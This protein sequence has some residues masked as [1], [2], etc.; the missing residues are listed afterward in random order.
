MS[1]QTDKYTPIAGEPPPTPPE[2]RPQKRRWLNIF[3]SLVAALV[4]ALASVVCM[5]LLRLTAGIPTPVELFGDFVLKRLPVN[6]FVDLLARFQP[7]PKTAPLGLTLLAMI[8]LGVVLGPLYVLLAQVAVPTVGWRPG[9]REWIVM[10]LLGSHN[11]RSGNSSVLDRDPTEFFGL[12]DCLG[13][14][15]LGAG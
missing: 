10:I 6:R 12:A 8:G 13:D 15:H 7:N 2:S 4:A 14:T 1:V 3:L 11:G 5:L 9:R